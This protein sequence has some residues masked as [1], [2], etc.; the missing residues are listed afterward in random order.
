LWIYYINPTVSDTSTRY[1]GL[2]ALMV[3]EMFCAII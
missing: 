2:E 3:E 1:S